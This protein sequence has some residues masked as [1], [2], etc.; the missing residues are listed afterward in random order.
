MVFNFARLFRPLGPA[1]PEIDPAY[2]PD[3][4]TSYNEGPITEPST[5]QLTESQNDPLIHFQSL[6]I[7]AADAQAEFQDVTFVGGV[8][9]ADVPGE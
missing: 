1:D 6:S 5:N 7:D 2:L 4:I 9:V 8:P 3:N